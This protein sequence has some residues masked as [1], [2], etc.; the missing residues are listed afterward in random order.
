MTA[1]VKTEKECLEIQYSGDNIQFF[2][3][4]L[5]KYKQFGDDSLSKLWSGWLVQVSVVKR[6]SVLKWLILSV[7]K[8]R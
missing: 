7:F 8:A 3:S 1:A 5:M 6:V 2:M 4:S